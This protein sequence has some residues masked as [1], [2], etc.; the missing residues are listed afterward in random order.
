[1]YLWNTAGCQCRPHPHPLGCRAWHCPAA[2][3]RLEVT[4]NSKDGSWVF[5]VVFPGFSRGIHPFE[6]EMPGL[7]LFCDCCSVLECLIGL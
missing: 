7:K 1:M 4:Q 3:P 6:L 2:H 5:R